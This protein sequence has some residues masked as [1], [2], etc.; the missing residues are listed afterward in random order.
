MGI[1]LPEVPE[2]I[3]HWVPVFGPLRTM[4]IKL[5]EGKPITLD[6]HIANITGGGSTV[7]QDVGPVVVDALG[8]QAGIP[9]LR[10][11]LIAAAAC[12]ALLLLLLVVI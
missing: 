4:A 5:Y 12:V 7:V 9:D 11:L 1:E 2:K 3:W 6:D 8:Q 10:W